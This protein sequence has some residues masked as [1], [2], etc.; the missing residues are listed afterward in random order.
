[1]NSRSAM[2]RINRVYWEDVNLLAKSDWGFKIF[3][4]LK[5]NQVKNVGKKN[6]IEL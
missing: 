4:R 1:M 5:G 3:H 6:P 2:F